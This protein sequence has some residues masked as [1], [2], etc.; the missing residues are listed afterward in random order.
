MIGNWI[1]TLGMEMKALPKRSSWD[2]S[3]KLTLQL[4]I[5]LPFFYGLRR[6]VGNGGGK[7]ET[8]K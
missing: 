2:F 3:F 4:Q 7:D 8:D 6:N 5:N 1:P